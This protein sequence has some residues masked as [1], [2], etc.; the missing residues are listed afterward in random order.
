MMHRHQT[1][2]R[3][4]AEIDATY[5]RLSGQEMPQTKSAQS[6]VVQTSFQSWMSTK[7]AEA[8]GSNRTNH[9][10]A[11]TTLSE[12]PFMNTPF[13]PV[14]MHPVAR[15]EFIC[16][17]SLTNLTR[18]GSTHPVAWNPGRTG[19]HLHRNGRR[20]RLKPLEHTAKGVAIGVLT[21][22]HLEHDHVV[23][24]IGA[25]APD[26]PDRPASASSTPRTPQ[27]EAER[28]SGAQSA[29]AASLAFSP[30]QDPG[31]AEASYEKM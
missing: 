6:R 20:R 9:I 30:L 4:A 18:M 13:H 3:P 7:G 21:A 12:Y 31:A 28:P 29:M 23:G 22:V 27:K 24:T 11:L 2:R 19:A 14:G 5:A 8:S 25:L 17:R 15:N 1:L 10:R 16:Q 26:A